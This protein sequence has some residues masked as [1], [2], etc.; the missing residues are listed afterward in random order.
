MQFVKPSHLHIVIWL[1]FSLLHGWSSITIL[2]NKILRV[3]LRVTS[4]TLYS[5]Y[6]YYEIQNFTLFWNFRLHEGNIKPNQLNI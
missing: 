3:I 4:V 1:A 6:L 5:V 2:L